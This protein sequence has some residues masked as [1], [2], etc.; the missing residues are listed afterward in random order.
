MIVIIRRRRRRRLTIFPPPLLLHTTII[1]AV[2][3]PQGVIPSSMSVDVFS[4][5]YH[6]RPLS[7]GCSIRSLLN[8]W[9]WEVGRSS[10]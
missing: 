3:F 4:H 7:F 5:I 10:C 8:K 6:K 9:A 2:A 1:P